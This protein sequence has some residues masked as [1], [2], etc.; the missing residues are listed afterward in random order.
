VTAAVPLI[1]W[2]VR[3]PYEIAFTTRVGGVSDGP[4]AS[5]NLGRKSGDAP[6]NVDEN[7]RRVCTGIGADADRLAINFQVHGTTVNQ[8][9]AGV[10]GEVR[11]DGL[12]TEEPGL[13][14]L[15]LT[16]DCVPIALA[17]ANGSPAVAVLH[18]GRIG[19]LAGLV[20]AAVA[21][22]GA[23]LAAAVG[24]AIGPCCYEVGDEIADP[25][26]ARFGSGI[27]RDG[28]LDLWTASEL[29][30]REAGCAR[31]ERVDLCTACNP[32]RFFSYR[33][34]GRPHGGQG[35]IAALA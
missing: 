19:L 32:E 9:S 2:D 15:A 27:V 23:P 17:R 35:V 6:A 12:F 29:L 30:L 28:R 22:L 8:A 20:E 4:Y 13:P 33:R 18:A 25:Y 3:G 31:V 21:R 7:R 16:A 5:L 24:P 11:G 26:R 14:V 1:R 34:E 10:R